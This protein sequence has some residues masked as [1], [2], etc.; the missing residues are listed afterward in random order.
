M[1]KLVQ[2]LRYHKIVIMLVMLVFGGQ[3]MAS[4]NI[5]CQVQGS[6]PQSMQHDMADHTDHMGSN[7]ATDSAASISCCPD[8]DCSV[9]GCSASAVLPIAYY[10]FSTDVVLLTSQHN[11]LALDQFTVS[12][13]RPPISR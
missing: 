10:L 7:V 8:C 5:S 1:I 11:E 6:T 4:A 3:V 2:K 13:F 12:L 9:G